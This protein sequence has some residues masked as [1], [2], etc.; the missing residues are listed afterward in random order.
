MQHAVE[1]NFRDKNRLILCKNCTDIADVFMN[2]L[3]KVYIRLAIEYTNLPKNNF[4][5][6]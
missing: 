1:L 4:K 6:W 2:G 3:K 5:K